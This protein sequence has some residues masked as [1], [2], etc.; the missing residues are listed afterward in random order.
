VRRYLG[1]GGT[2][3]V[4]LVAAAD[5]GGP[6]LSYLIA[7]A[8]RLDQGRCDSLFSILEPGPLARTS[9]LLCE[10]PF[11][12]YPG[13]WIRPATARRPVRVGDGDVEAYVLGTDFTYDDLRMWTPRFITAA[14]RVAPAQAGGVELLTV[15]AG[16][17]Y[18]RTTR[19]TARALVERR[20]GVPIEVAWY[21]DGAAAPFRT[22]HA[23]GIA[24]WGGV[25]MPETI[26]V[27][28][29]RDGY[30]SSM[31]LLGVRVS[32]SAAPLSGASR[33]A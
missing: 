21:E 17:L 23:R 33:A 11:D 13:V 27:R 3:L 24:A 22:L 10:R 4:R 29:P 12:A 28:R 9:V 31:E 32:E 25:W 15:S 16:W 18:R 1:R 5:G 26:T 2:R 6:V 14:S 30:T 7:H 8:W 20:H 19:V